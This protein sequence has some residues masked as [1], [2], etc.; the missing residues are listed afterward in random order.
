MA[1]QEWLC[2]RQLDCEVEEAR[3]RDGVFEFM[4]MIAGEP[5]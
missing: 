3:L 2:G 5:Y 1:D 4:E